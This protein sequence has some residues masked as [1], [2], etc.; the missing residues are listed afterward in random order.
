ME[1]GW[2]PAGYEDSLAEFIPRNYKKDKFGTI[3]DTDLSVD[4]EIEVS[5]IEDSTLTR[6]ALNKDK[7]KKTP[8]KNASRYS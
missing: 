7:Y 2:H 3:F 1:A 5:K 6:R 4:R 8:Y